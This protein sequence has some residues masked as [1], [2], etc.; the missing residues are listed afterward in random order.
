MEYLSGG[1]L[2]DFI[3]KVY[4]TERFVKAIDASAI[5]KQILEAVAYLHEFDIAH[6]GLKPSTILAPTHRKYNVC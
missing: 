2:K 5:I 1:S 3:R 6:R 4:D